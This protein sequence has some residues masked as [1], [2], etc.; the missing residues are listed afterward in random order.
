[1]K[2]HATVCDCYEVEGISPE[3]VCRDLVRGVRGEKGG[4]KMWMVGNLKRRTSYDH[5]GRRIKK[6]SLVN[7]DLKKSTN[8]WNNL[9]QNLNNKSRDQLFLVN[10]RLKLQTQPW[11]P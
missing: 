8:C 7:K 6:K 3:N 9:S 4:E 11:I 2:I 1:M 10:L 5:E